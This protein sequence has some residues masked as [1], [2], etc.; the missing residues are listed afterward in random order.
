MRPLALLV[1]IATLAPAQEATEQ[2]QGL[3]FLAGSWAGPMWGGVFETWYS[4]PEGGKVLSSSLLIS[5]GNIRFWEFEKF[6][7][8]GE[9]VWVQPFPNGKPA[10]SF[11]LVELDVEAKKATFD[12][13]TND[14]PT[15]IVYE[16]N[17]EG[18]L[19]IT[20]SDPHSGS[21]KVEV[22]DL[23]PQEDAVEEVD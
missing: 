13:T 19:V 22:F 21:P 5:E 16:K 15:R 6:E 2:I 4:T 18:H 7:V 23:A 3:D 8:R 10:A 17:E 9:H 12:C 14:F 20:L 11:R 1:L